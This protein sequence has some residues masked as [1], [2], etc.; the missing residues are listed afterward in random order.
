[1]GRA[2]FVLELRVSPERGKATTMLGQVIVLM[3]MTQ[4][5]AKLSGVTL[6]LRLHTLQIPYH[7]LESYFMLPAHH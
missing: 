2:W 1:M 7:S 3:T 5:I 4:S 6:A